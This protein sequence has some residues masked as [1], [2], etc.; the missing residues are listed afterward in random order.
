M[1]LQHDTAL[2]SFMKMFAQSDF[3]IICGRTFCFGFCLFLIFLFF[4]MNIAENLKMIVRTAYIG[5]R[6]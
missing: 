6:W 2:L 1:R 3:Y 4:L 5:V